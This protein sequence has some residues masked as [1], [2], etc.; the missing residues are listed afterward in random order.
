[1]KINDYKKLD[2]G[3]YVTLRTK[4]GPNAKRMG[5]IV[6]KEENYVC[7]KPIPGQP[8][9]VSKDTHHNTVPLMV[10]HYNFL[11]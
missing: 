3:D 7:L 4:H 9:F 10:I 8:M 6:Y 1:M 2:I 5:E 11:E